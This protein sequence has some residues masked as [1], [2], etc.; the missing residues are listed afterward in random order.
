M[1]LL[2]SSWSSLIIVLIVVV[3]VLAGL[4][5]A[6]VVT[7][8]LVVGVASVGIVVAAES[9]QRNQ[10]RGEVGDLRLIVVPLATMLLLIVMMLVIVTLILVVVVIG[11]GLLRVMRVALIVM[12]SLWLA[13]HDCG[14]IMFN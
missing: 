4:L 5:V 10:G 3:L 12:A 14:R 11:V 8:I 7:S 2:A 9:S 13:R 1:R 6:F